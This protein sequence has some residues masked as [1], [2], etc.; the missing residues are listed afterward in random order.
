MIQ[1]KSFVQ[2]QS[3]F[4]SLYIQTF[5]GPQYSR[6]LLAH[7]GRRDLRANVSIV[8]NCH[9]ANRSTPSKMS[10]SI[11]S[12]LY[13]Q[14]CRCLLWLVRKS[15]CPV[16]LIIFPVRQTMYRDCALLAKCGRQC[17]FQVQ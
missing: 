2:S 17:K 8:V 13:S 11:L 5:L 9:P 1:V 10:V 3:L 14:R 12:L 15:N 16:Y 6:S 4:L 7:N